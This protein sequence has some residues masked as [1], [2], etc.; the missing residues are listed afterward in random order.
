M[1]GSFDAANS[2]VFPRLARYGLVEK[3]VLQKHDQKVVALV[4]SKEE[5]R[6]RPKKVACSTRYSLVGAAELKCPL[7]KQP[8][9][10]KMG[11]PIVR[12]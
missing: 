4:K 8:S 5:H 10:L 9:S 1:F 2:Q 11:V 6:P 3:L 7:A 12:L